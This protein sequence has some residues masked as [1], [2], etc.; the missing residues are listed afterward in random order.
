MQD[1]QRIN[2]AL[3]EAGLPQVLSEKDFFDIFGDAGQP[4]LNELIRF[5]R[6][7]ILRVLTDPFNEKRVE[8][9]AEAGMLNEDTID[10]WALSNIRKQLGG[11]DN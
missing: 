2:E 7:A 9:M 10:A 4:V 11:L 6:N 3:T 5:Q 8:L 1:D